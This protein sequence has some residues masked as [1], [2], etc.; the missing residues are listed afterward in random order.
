MMKHA[1]VAV[2]LALAL[3]APALAETAAPLK[4]LTPGFTYYA[5]VADLGAGYQKE[6]GVKVTVQSS[7]MGKIMNDAKTGEPAADIV[8]LPTNLMDQLQAEKGIVPGSRIFIGRVRMALAVHKGD[9]VPDISTVPKLAA[10]LKSADSVMRSNP[11]GGSMVAAII[12]KMLQR[13][14]FAGVK[15][16]VSPYG[17]GGQAVMRGEGQMAIQAECEIINHPDY[18]TNVGPVPDEL[19]AYMDG[20]AAVLTRSTNPKAAADWLKYATQPGTYSL[21]LAKGLERMKR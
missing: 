17:E 19:G 1:F 3:G 6:K 2:L 9:P 20:E 15:H 10:V 7:G 4:I 16:K 11:V 14:E 13:P 18:L 8:F 21:W 12:D 5:G